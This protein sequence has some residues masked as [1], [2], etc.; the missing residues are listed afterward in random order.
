ME[1]FWNN[2]KFIKTDYAAYFNS[3]TT[4]W[5]IERPRLYQHSD[6]PDGKGLPMLATDFNIEKKGEVKIY[7]S[8]L[9]CNDIY[10]NGKRVGKDEMKPGWT[11]Y[12]IRT[13]YFEYD[14]TD[15][16]TEGK[17]RILAVLSSGWYS[18]RIVGDYYG[19]NPPAFIASITNDGEKVAVT[20]ENWKGFLGGQI[21]IADIW[22]GEIRDNTFDSYEKMSEVGFDLSEWKN[23]ELADYAK[24]EVSE[25]IGPKIQVRDNLS[26]KSAKAVIYDG[27]KY[28]GTNYGEINVYN[29]N[30]EFPLMLKKGQTLVIDLA[31]EI[32]GWGNFKFKGSKGNRIKMRYAEFLNDSGDIS[33]GNDGPK[34]SVYTI[35]LRSAL[36]KAYCVLNGDAEETYRPTFTF[37]GFRYIEITADDDVEILDF[38]G[39]VVGNAIEEIGKLETSD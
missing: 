10:I 19:D 13:S 21:R 7:F 14:I 36:G 22:D 28:N 31:Q 27:I 26:L 18:G 9:G 29:D 4:P 6:L 12:W 1:K 11:N 17:N 23:A 20:D 15:Y 39:E 24:C 37:F 3:S 32:V 35:N 38:T 25:F 5:G 33:R 16:V 30:A 2:A 8:S 34:G